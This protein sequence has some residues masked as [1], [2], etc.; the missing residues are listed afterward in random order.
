MLEGFRPQRQVF[1]NSVWRYGIPVFGKQT[2]A[3][4]VALV[5]RGWGL[6]GG[7]NRLP[8]SGAADGPAQDHG[9][10]HRGKI[11]IQLRHTMA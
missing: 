2:A 3:V 8:M 9:D 1:I 11:A 4:L 7:M 5:G 10:W 6:L